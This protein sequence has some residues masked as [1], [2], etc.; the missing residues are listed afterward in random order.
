MGR[1]WRHPKQYRQ[2]L[3]PPRP[4]GRP[5]TSCGGRRPTITGLAREA[6]RHIGLSRGHRGAIQSHNW[7]AESCPGSE[8]A[9]RSRA[10]AFPRQ[11]VK[12]GLLVP[13]RPPLTAHAH[14]IKMENKKKFTFNFSRFT[15]R[16]ELP[17]LR[18]V[19]VKQATHENAS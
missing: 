6:S 17:L 7:P 4:N 2:Y 1:D 19:K 14:Y 9:Q 18:T 3:F 10:P 15:I 11:P 5:I 13:S 12:A 16:A 8:L